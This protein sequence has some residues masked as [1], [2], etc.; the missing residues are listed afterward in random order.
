[1]SVFIIAEIGINHNGDVEIAKQMIDLACEAGCDAVKFQKRDPD[2]CVPEHQ[3]SIMRETPW[4]TMTYLEYKY[5]IEFGEKEYDTIDSYCKQ[6]GIEWFASAWD[7]NSFSFLKKYDFKHNKIA[8][9]MLTYKPLLIEV[10]K[11]KKHTFVSTGMSTM[12]EVA[13]AYGVFED[14]SCP[15]ELMHCVS[16][17]PMEDADA[18]LGMIQTLKN[19]FGCNVGYSGHERGLHITGVAVALGATSIERHITLDRAMYG[20]DQAASL[21][22]SGLIR[23]VRNVRLTKSI[24]GDGKKKI[25][26]EELAMRKKLSGG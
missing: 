3:K 16:I 9:A 25:L 6:K 21:E 4:G 7:L 19:R 10:A 14:Y 23:L 11:E 15:I 5:R 18:N 17:Y 20:T 26:D 24:I 22:K 8:S 1:M 12:K 2:I 13:E